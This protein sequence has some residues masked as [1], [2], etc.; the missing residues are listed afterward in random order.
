M[1][2]LDYREKARTAFIL[3][4]LLCQLKG[5]DD[6]VY[7]LE[8]RRDLITSSELLQDVREAEL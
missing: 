3:L 1:K 4:N 7:K 5:I 8:L 6:S 2:E